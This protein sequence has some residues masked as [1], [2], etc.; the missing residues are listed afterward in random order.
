MVGSGCE[1]ANTELAVLD[2]VKTISQDRCSLRYRVLDAAAFAGFVWRI[3]RLR[4]SGQRSRRAKFALALFVVDQHIFCRRGHD[5]L[6]NGITVQQ[7]ASPRKLQV[8]ALYGLD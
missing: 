5:G 4:P 7:E 6:K 8:S 3:R 2:I 1:T